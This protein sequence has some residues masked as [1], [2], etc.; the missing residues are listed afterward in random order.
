MCTV[1]MNP[2]IYEAG[3]LRVMFFYVFTKVMKRQDI[4]NE[5]RLCEDILKCGCCVILSHLII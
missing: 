3:C 4:N 1:S 2:R 5:K